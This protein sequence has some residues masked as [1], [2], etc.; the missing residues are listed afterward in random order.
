MVEIKPSLLPHTTWIDVER[1]QDTLDWYVQET[2][3]LEHCGILV[4]LFG[5]VCINVANV[6]YFRHG[7]KVPR[8][9]YWY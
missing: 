6:A 4:L 8:P 9:L 1:Q 5:L 2:M 7:T 3:C